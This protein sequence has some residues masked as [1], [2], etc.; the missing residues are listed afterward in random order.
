MAYWQS[1]ERHIGPASG[2][3]GLDYDGTS[4]WP[5]G[6]P[7]SVTAPAPGPFPSP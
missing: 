6:W 1:T 7:N 4:Y 3:S 5:A 2:S